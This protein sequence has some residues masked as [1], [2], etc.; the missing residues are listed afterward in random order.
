MATMGST[1]RTSAITIL[2]THTVGTTATS[3]TTTGIITDTTMVIITAITQ[4]LTATDMGTDI[5]TVSVTT[6]LRHL[7][8]LEAA[9][10]ALLTTADLDK[11]E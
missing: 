8:P 4:A 6:T 7:V 2:T 1:I 5:T 11:V 10:P 9:H 3:E